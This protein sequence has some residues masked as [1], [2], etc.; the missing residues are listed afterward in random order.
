MS[1]VINEAVSQDANIQPPRR[2]QVVALTVDATPRA[3]ALTGLT[4][5]AQKFQQN[6]NEHLF[7]TLRNDNATTNLYYLFSDVISAALDPTLAVAAG[8]PL[9][10]SDAYGDFIP[11]SSAV[12]VR[13]QRGIDKFLIVRTGTGTAILRLYPSSESSLQ[14][15]A[16]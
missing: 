3:Y 1:M 2:G 10:F 8:S 13:I 6:S 7:L 12:N 16:S 14:I 5:N 9:A 11:P 15:G 4:L